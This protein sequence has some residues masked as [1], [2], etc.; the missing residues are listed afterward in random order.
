MNTRGAVGG[1][2]KLPSE[3]SALWDEMENDVADERWP[4]P[5]SLMLGFWYRGPSHELRRRAAFRSRPN[6]RFVPSRW[7]PR[8]LGQ[9]VFNVAFLIWLQWVSARSSIAHQIPFLMCLGAATVAL[10]MLMTWA[11]RTTYRVAFDQ[12]AHQYFEARLTPAIALKAAG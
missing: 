9:Q 8:P 7:W 6:A 11:I 3:D 12:R 2:L 5:F 4:L 10:G 1:H